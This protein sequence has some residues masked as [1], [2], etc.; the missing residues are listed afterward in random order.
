MLSPFIIIMFPNPSTHPHP[1]THPNPWTPPNPCTPSNPY[2]H[3]CTQNLQRF[4]ISYGICVEYIKPLERPS[5]QSVCCVTPL[6]WVNPREIDQ[7]RARPN[8][9]FSWKFNHLLVKTSWFYGVNFIFFQTI[10]KKISNFKLFRL[11][12]L[13]VL[14]VFLFKNLVLINSNENF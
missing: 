2:T 9:R 10:Q 12:V 14:R 3:T 13:R 7:C 1:W 6:Y 4:L 11:F 8:H 5:S